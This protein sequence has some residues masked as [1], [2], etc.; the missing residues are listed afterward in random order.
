MLGLITVGSV[1]GT[2]IGCVMAVSMCQKNA[3][4][5]TKETISKFE[6]ESGS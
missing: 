4:S 1:L 2:L 3:R 6:K 5:S